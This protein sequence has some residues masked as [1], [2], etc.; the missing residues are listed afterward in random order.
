LITEYLRPGNGGVATR[1]EEHR[2]LLITQLARNRS[3]P[4]ASDSTPSQ[5][6]RIEPDGMTDL[7]KGICL[8]LVQVC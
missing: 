5:L 1:R 3:R 7:R 6:H 8:C 4:A 2:G